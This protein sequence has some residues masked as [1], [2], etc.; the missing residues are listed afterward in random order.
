MPDEIRIPV[1]A[2]IPKSLHDSILAAVEAEQYKDK[3]TC[4]TEALEKLLNNTQEETQDNSEILQEMKDELQ[5]LQSEIQANYAVIQSKD[6]ELQNYKIVLQNKENEIHRLQSVIQEA[7][8]PLELAEMKGNYAGLQKV[9][10]E[11]DKRIEALE[12]EVSRL[13]MFAHYFKNVEV[14]QIEA[15]ITEKKKPWYKFW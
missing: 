4:I 7:P 14:K 8:D 13:D 1:N 12:R 6:A 3:T 10:Q 5:K 9:I 11:K 15:P 2:K